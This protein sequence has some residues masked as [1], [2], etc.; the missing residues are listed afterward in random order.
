[1]RLSWKPIEGVDGYTVT[2]NQPENEFM[3]G[4]IELNT[5]QTF[6]E[7]MYVFCMVWYIFKGG[8]GIANH[9]TS[10]KCCNFY[11]NFRKNI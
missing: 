11:S 8:G 1:M 3:N 7:G 9:A 2:H 6:I 4:N 10:F 5:T